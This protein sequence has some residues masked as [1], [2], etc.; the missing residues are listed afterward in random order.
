MGVRPDPR[1]CQ[2]QCT[3][4][5]RLI[6]LLRSSNK[7]YLG[8]RLWLAPVPVWRGQNSVILLGKFW[9][10]KILL[11][12]LYGYST[13]LV[14]SYRLSNYRSKKVQNRQKIG[15]E[16][17]FLRARGRHCITSGNVNGAR[18]Y[19]RPPTMIA[20]AHCRPCP[21]RNE[22][23]SAGGPTGIPLTIQEWQLY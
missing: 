21:V 12:K 2:D 19:L 17:N 3:S 1:W 8:W 11:V 20:S 9:A 14:F 15:A 18:L 22:Q 16:L 23:T 13:N 7:V 10:H 5:S 4:A 6:V